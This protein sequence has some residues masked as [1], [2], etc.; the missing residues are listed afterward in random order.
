MF[1]VLS[2]CFVVFIVGFVLFV[3]LGLFV[4][5]LLGCVFC[6]FYVVKVDIKFF[7]K[8][9]QVVFVCD[10][11]RIV[12]IMV[13]DYCG[14]FKEFVMV[15]LV[16]IFFECEQIYVVE[17][18]FIDYLDIYMLFCFVEYFDENFCWC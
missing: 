9:L 2:V 16:L 4:S 14:D 3:L 5:V 6:G 18:F 1:Y 12:V 11:D 10:G 15:I 13:S 8:V 7:N 17:Q